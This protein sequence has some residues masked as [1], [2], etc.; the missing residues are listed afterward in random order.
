MNKFTLALIL[1]AFSNIILAQDSPIFT[2]RPNVTDAVPLISPGTFQVELGYTNTT[3]NARVDDIKSQTIPNLS[4]KYGLFD[5]LELRMLTNYL[6]FNFQGLDAHGVT[7]LIFSPKFRLL[8][9]NGAIPRTSLVTNVTIPNIGAKAFQ[10]DEFGY[11]LVLL[12]EYGFNQ[13]T[14]SNSFSSNLSF[15]TVGGYAIT[16][17]FGAF[18]EFYGSFKNDRGGLNTD[19]GLS[20]LLA[21]NF[22]VDVIYGTG[23]VDDFRMFGFGC[24]WKTNFRE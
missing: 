1:L 16:N 17:K 2:D 6:V 11:N 21:Q 12:F 4:V 7:P 10:A 14:W 5:W 13:F 20:Y 3:Q 22:Q 19:F 15:T 8:E 18:L 9:Q 23:F 24:A